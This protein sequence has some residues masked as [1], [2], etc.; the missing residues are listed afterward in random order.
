VEVTLDNGEV[1]V[2]E[3]GPPPGHRLKPFSDADFEEKLRVN[4]EPVMGAQRTRDI[5]EA[6]RTLDAAASLQ[7]LCGL[8]GA[9]AKGVEAP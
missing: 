2:G 4:V 7:P 1:I 8:L 3:A 5:L 6:V 9:G